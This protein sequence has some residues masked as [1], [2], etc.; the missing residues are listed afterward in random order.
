VIYCEAAELAAAIRY[1]Q[2]WGEM[3]AGYELIEDDFQN[4]S[5]SK[6]L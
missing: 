4:S 5:T 3:P 1:F 6:V 2:K